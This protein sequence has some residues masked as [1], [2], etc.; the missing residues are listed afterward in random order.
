MAEREHNS[1][2]RYGRYGKQKNGSYSMWDNLRYTFFHLVQKEGAGAFLICAGDGMC[3][4]LLPF[5]EAALAGAVT[6]CLVSGRPSGEILFLVGGYILLLQTVRLLQ[7]H[8]K[9]LRHKTLFLFRCDMMMEF[10][11]KILGMDT[12]CLESAQGQKKREAAKRN[13]YSGH[14]QGI[15]AY[16]ENFWNLLLNLGGLFLYAGIVARTSLWLL[17]LLVSQTFL[18]SAL[19]LLAGR[20]VYAMDEEMEQEWKKFGYLRRES[21]VP[22]NG[23]DIRLYRMDRWFVG[24]LQ[25][26]IE[27]ICKLTVKGQDGFLAA[28]VVEK[29]LTFA[30]NAVVYGWLIRDMVLGNL[31]LPVFLLYVGVVSGFEGWMGGLFDSVQQILQNKRLMDDYRD[32]MEYGSVEEGRAPVGNPGQPH[33]LRLEKVCFRYEGSKEDTIH[34]LDLTIRAGERLALVGCNGAG[35]TTLIK[36]LCGL[37]APT[38]GHIY[39]DGQDMQTLSR[40]EIF[41]EFAVVFQDCTTFSFSLG[42]NVSCVEKGREEDEKLQKSLADAG[43]LERAGKLPGGIWTSVNKDLDE[44]GV[45]LSGGEMQKLMLARALYKNAPI[46]ILDEPTAALDP[47]AE[48]EMY[49]KYDEMIQGKTAIFISHRLSSTRFCN[50]I[51]YLEDGRIFQEGSHE[52]LMAEGGAYAALFALQA[53]YYKQDTV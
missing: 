38:S 45:S 29:L 39:L 18:A 2:C 4:I 41:W 50:R 22:A 11:G 25:Q 53:K 24:A 7:G 40:K 46:V 34:D 44:E 6:A 49:E 1:K 33:E 23:K 32:F 10:Y 37:Y 9:A 5:L 20:R 8:L 43:L 13:L 51:L 36:M 30:R 15:E 27:K 26:V 47:I 35:K 17:V 19:H 52:E 3:S 16:V 14:S 48:S 31:A 12:Q 42:E 21:I 28:G